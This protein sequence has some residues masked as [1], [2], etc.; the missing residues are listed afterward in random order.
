MAGENLVRPKGFKATV[1]NFWYHYKFHTIVCLLLVITLAVSIA[2]CSTKT[3]YD[4]KIVV[5]TKSMPLTTTQLTALKNELTP[6]GT[7]LNGDGQVNILLVDCTMDSNPADYQNNLAKQQKLQAILMSD[8]DV[9]LFITDLK[10]FSFI[11]NLNDTGF[12]EN[13]NLPD[14]DGYY[15]DFTNTDII[16]NTKAAADSKNLFKW[17]EFLISRRII[18]GTLFEGRD[19]VN[20]NMKNADAFIE[21]V[22][23]GTTK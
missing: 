20:E 5:A 6:Y 7:D 3:E 12:I 16:K 21:R 15:Y 4:Y 8:T 18:K 1:E 11:K 2:Q 14:G 9:M 17:P 13:L 23:S 22:I 10:A 19:G